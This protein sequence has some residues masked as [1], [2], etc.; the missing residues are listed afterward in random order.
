MYPPHNKLEGAWWAFV[1]RS[2]SHHART[3]GFRKFLEENDSFEYAGLRW[4]REAVS[5]RGFKGNRRRW[6]SVF[7]SLDD[8]VVIEHPVIIER[9]QN[10]EDT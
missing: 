4:K 6:F 10:G 9:R 5:K 3:P 2:C 7:I 1:E 8:G